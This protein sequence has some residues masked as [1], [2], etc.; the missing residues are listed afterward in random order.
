MMYVR[1]YHRINF[2]VLK[3]IMGIF[4][5][6]GNLVIIRQDKRVVITQEPKRSS[7]VIKEKLIPGDGPIITYRKIREELIRKN[8]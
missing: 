7:L 8:S 3:Q 2:P 1:Q 5:N 6:L 4:G